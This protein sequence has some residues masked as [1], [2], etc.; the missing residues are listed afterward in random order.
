MKKIAVFILTHE[1]ADI[2]ED[3]LNHEMSIF[4]QNNLDVFILDSS[5][6]HKINRLYY[7]FKAKNKIDNMYYIHKEPSISVEE[8]WIHAINWVKE[9]SYEYVWFLSDCYGVTERLLSKVLY[10]VEYECEVIYLNRMDG[11]GI[12]DK[13]FTNCNE[14][15]SIAWYATLLPTLIYNVKMLSGVDIYGALV[16]YKTWISVG[17][18]FE[19]FAKNEKM[20]AMHL[21]VKGSEYDFYISPLKK[22][23]WWRNNDAVYKTICED[24]L[25]MIDSLPDVYTEKDEFAKKNCDGELTLD[26]LIWMRHIKLFTIKEYLKYRKRLYRVTRIDRKKLLIIS[27]LPI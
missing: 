19:Q 11:N 23:S 3:T 13:I 7:K 16:K 10:A 26:D 27:L 12:G 14:F 22:L 18:L 2:L 25:D 1:R 15:Y 6:S 9:K 20:R 24:M 5:M 4:N 21:S 17:I 8:K